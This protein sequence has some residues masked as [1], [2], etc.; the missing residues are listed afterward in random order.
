MGAEHGAG[1]THLAVALQGIAGEW[2]GYS[3]TPCEWFDQLVA[4]HI[5]IRAN[6]V[7]AT[8]WILMPVARHKVLN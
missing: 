5:R 2:Q 6:G 4:N 3:V 7:E 1:Q 8:L